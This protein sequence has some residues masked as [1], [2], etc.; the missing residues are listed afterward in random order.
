MPTNQ[1][2]CHAQ[3]VCFQHP[4]TGQSGISAWRTFTG[5][6]CETTLTGSLISIGVG[7]WEGGRFSLD[8]VVMPSGSMYSLRFSLFFF[9]FS[10]FSF[11]SFSFLAFLS[12]FFLGF[13][14]RRKQAWGSKYS[15]N[16]AKWHFHLLLSIQLLHP[17]DKAGEGDKARVWKK[18]RRREN[19]RHR[20]T[21]TTRERETDRGR[22]RERDSERHK[23][24]ENGERK[25]REAVREQ[26]ME[27]EK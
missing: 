17:Q 9:L 5:E 19:K 1:I 12:F 27:K 4:C 7:C 16:F 26:R 2:F 6:L 3:W 20:Q 10:F 13:C 21:E 8:G 18:E 25:K 11:F 23:E 15:F 24:R 22:E 14:K